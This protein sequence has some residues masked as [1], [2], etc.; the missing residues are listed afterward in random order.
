[1]MLAIFIF[2]VSIVLLSSN[3]HFYFKS[4]NDVVKTY[5]KIGMFYVIIPHHKMFSKLVF[6]N[7]EFIVNMK[8]SFKLFKSLTFNIFSH[9][10]IDRIYIAKFSKNKILESPIE[11]VLYLIF[12]NQLRGL[13]HSSFRYIDNDNIKL[14]YDE[15]YENIDYYLDAHISIFNLILASI[16][17]IFKR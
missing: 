6:S 16:K 1:M 14:E 2:L 11:N 3:I 15:G 13:L 4:K 12:A 7:N 9:S 8:N 5:I 10:I 17:T